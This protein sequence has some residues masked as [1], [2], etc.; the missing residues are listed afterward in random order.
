MISNDFINNFLKIL[1][2]YKVVLL[3][4]IDSYAKSKAT[5]FVKEIQSHHLC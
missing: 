5:S 2:N 3:M 1:K 4:S